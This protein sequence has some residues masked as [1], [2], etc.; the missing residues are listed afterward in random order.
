MCSLFPFLSLRPFEIE[1]ARSG[2]DIGH[3][4][5]GRMV[6]NERN[7][8]ES[9]DEL[10]VFD[11]AFGVEYILHKTLQTFFSFL[12]KVADIRLYFH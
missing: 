2:I 1:R 12:P 6:V 8:V 11:V 10:V 5:A 9:D 3:S 4:I 7:W